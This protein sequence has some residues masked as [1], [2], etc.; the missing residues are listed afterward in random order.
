MLPAKRQKAA[1]IAGRRI[2]LIT[3][4]CIDICLKRNYQV[5]LYGSAR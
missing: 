2:V 4:E 1:S 3:L 5:H